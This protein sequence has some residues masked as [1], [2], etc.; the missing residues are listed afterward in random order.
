MKFAT[1]T[2]HSAQPSEPGTGALMAPIFQT[3]TFEQTAPGVHRGFDYTRT[4]NPTRQRLED[5]LADLEG[6]RHAALFASGLGAEN[7]VFQALLEPGDEVILPPDVYGG[8]FRLLDRVYAVKGYRVTRVDL[9]DS[10]ALGQALQ[11]KPRLVWLETPTNPRLMIYDIASIVEAAHPQGTL[12]AVDNTLA[13]PYFQ[14]PFEWGA[15]LVVHSVT[16]YLSGHSDL[17][18]GAVLASD[19]AV[20]EPI[21][22]IQNAAGGTPSP[23]DCWLTLRGIKT[24][25]LRLER[26]AENARI[27]ADRLQ[28]HPAVEQVYYPGLPSHPGYSVACRQMQGFGGMLSIKLRGSKQDLIEFA[29]NRRYFALAESLGGVKSLICH[30]ASMTHSSI[31]A[32]TREAMGVSDRLVRL[33]PGC[34]NACDLLEDLL[35]GLEK[36]ELKRKGRGGKN[37]QKEEKSGIAAQP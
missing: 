37:A 22:F 4:N 3:S 35:E 31:P 34:E 27:I 12:V 24:L 28:G 17:I 5:L 11:R 6:V 1:K 19:A 32:Q 30:P 29:S 14:R 16:K 25:E 7:A 33:S 10:Q 2:I 26:H 9:S 18:Q 23:F 20:F 21:R 8:T 36:A 13:T 15:D